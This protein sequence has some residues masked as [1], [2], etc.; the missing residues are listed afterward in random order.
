MW[1]IERE[2]TKSGLCVNNSPA[3]EGGRSWL[4]GNKT[5]G[6][7]TGERSSSVW[8]VRTCWFSWSVT[9]IFPEHTLW[10]RTQSAHR[11]KTPVGVV[12]GWFR[13]GDT[14]SQPLYIIDMIF[15]S[16]QTSQ[17]APTPCMKLSVC[18]M[19]IQVHTLIL[20]QCAVKR[21]ED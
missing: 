20:N 13:V 8:S 10:R 16:H 9:T 3:I 17:W 19:F 5:H 15:Y 21:K 18:V 7:T 2:M 12:I 1:Q 6:L 4:L 11:S 14:Q